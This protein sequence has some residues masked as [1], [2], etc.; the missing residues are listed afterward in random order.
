MRIVAAALLVLVALAG[1]S[2]NARDTDGDGLRDST[3]T[4][5]PSILVDYL[6]RRVRIFP[7]SDPAMIDT[8]G[9]GLSD[10]DEF[11]A[12]TDPRNR[13][14]D[15]DGLTDCQENVHS[16][17][18]ECEDPAFTGDYDGGFKTNPSRADSDPGPVR[19]PNRPGAFVDETGTLPGGH[20]EWGD[21][22][23]DGDEILGYTVRLSGGRER[24]V[25]SNPRSPDTDRDGLEDGEEAL[26]YG[27]DPLV[28]DTD[29][30]GCL[31]GQDPFPDR[32]EFYGLGLLTFTL[33]ADKDASGSDLVLS[34]QIA[35]RGFVAPPAGS[36]HVNRGET[37]DISGL[38]PP[39]FAGLSCP[40]GPRSPWVRL[41]LDAN[42]PDAGGTED[43]DIVSHHG[44]KAA[45]IPVILWNVHTDEFVWDESL[46]ALGKPISLEGNDAV[47]VFQPQ[48]VFSQGS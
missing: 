3:E 42:D 38:S 41:Q 29:G 8:D 22:I 48:V 10:F 21:G 47:L 1:C 34:G 11:F 5:W 19:Y 23:S 44:F 18:T 36:I 46:V 7:T 35:G 4:A 40:V 33:K 39:A 28:D 6:D 17:A 37:L 27:S 15:A 30:D 45:E 31:D 9:D 25:T 16:N 13:D 20:V 2:A 24:F 14:T 32:E 43:I 26:L 12:R